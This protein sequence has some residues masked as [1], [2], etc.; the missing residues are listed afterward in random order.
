[1]SINDFE[2]T[3]EDSG[4]STGQTNDNLWYKEKIREVTAE[5]NL[6]I[7]TDEV[8]GYWKVLNSEEY[9][10]RLFLD[11]DQAEKITNETVANHYEEIKRYLERWRERES[12]G[13]SFAQTHGGYSVTELAGKLNEAYAE[14]KGKR[15][16]EEYINAYL[17]RRKNKSLKSLDPVIKA[18]LADKVLTYE[19]K[20]MVYEAGVKLG[21]NITET[22]RYLQE[23]MVREGDIRDVSS[24]G[25]TVKSAENS[26]A[27]ASYKDDERL[28]IEDLKDSGMIEEYLEGGG[29]LTGEA[30]VEFYKKIR[31]SFAIT[32]ISEL[33]KLTE[34]KGIKQENE[35]GEK[36]AASRTKSVL[37]MVFVKGGIFLMGSTNGEYNE[38]PVH[39]VT[40]SDFM[41]GKYEVTQELW[42]SLMGNNPSWFT[43]DDNLPVERVSWYDAVEFC[44]KLSEKEGLQKVYC[45]SGDE[46][47]MDTNAN[48]YRLPTEA[49]W[50]YA[51]K[52]GS[53]SK[54]Y[55][56]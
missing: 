21:L 48:G 37:E 29:K 56:Y 23:E 16:R 20:M 8:W 12:T 39:V 5:G 27:T 55:K 54:G 32:G 7:P 35:T 49:E 44:N 26:T 34:E 2:L 40:V 22:D 41:I 28:T 24:S 50:E 3:S 25:N 10:E 30:W 46:I 47:K 11:I 4:S 6:K 51:A 42:K 18:V 14:L 1:M 52:G 38:E 15:S 31:Q 43:G 13:I 19:E 17:R 36:R 9:F 53:K 45:V 33:K